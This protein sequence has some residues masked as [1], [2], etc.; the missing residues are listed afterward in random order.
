MRIEIVEFQKGI[1]LPLLVDGSGIPIF[2]STVYIVNKYLTKGKSPNTIEAFLRA[3]MF[4]YAWAEKL[5]IDIE[6]RYSKGEFLTISEIENLLAVLALRYDFFVGDKPNQS[7]KAERP[8]VIKL[9]NQPAMLIEPT[10]AGKTQ[11]ERARFILSYLDFLA[12]DC[13]GRL[14]MKDPNHST[15]NLIRQQMKERF[16]A[17]IPMSKVSMRRQGL[18]LEEEGRLRNI[19]DPANPE[20]PWSDEFVKVRNQLIINMGLSLAN[21][22]GEQLSIRI[23][24]I[25]LMTENIDIVRR[26]KEDDSRKDK[27]SLKTGPRLIPLPLG[28]ELIE[29]IKTYLPI[30]R[31]QGD[32]QKHDFLIVARR[33][34]KPLARRSLMEIFN[35]IEE[36]FPEFLGK[37]S[38][39]VM[40]HS[41]NLRYSELCDKDNIEPEVER[42]RREYF[43][44]WVAGSPMSAHYTHRHNMEEVRKQAREMQQKKLPQK[45]NNDIQS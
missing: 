22:L 27:P 20:N 16:K 39:H 21:R 38:H 5:G 1:Q 23:S 18:T 36:K 14:S 30:R 44:G 33:T 35:E 10:V 25:N 31:K 24:D 37:L 13:L 41:W 3:V 12:Q 34:G 4:A 29:N 42:A 2:M 6:K 26:S 45:M 11:A 15:L 32:S 40:R 9:M 28:P 43:N 7:V 17:R 8:K 19:I